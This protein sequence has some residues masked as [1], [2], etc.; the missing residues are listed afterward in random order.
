MCSGFE[1]NEEE[2][3][4]DEEGGEGE[5]ALHLPVLSLVALSLLQLLQS[6]LHPQAGVLNVEVD[7]VHHLT[8]AA[9]RTLYI[10]LTPLPVFQES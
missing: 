8:L 1:E 10:P 6:L 5:D 3:E 9:P 2:E 4:D 7:A